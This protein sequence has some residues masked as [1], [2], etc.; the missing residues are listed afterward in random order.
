[1]T[2]YQL[3]DFLS[4]PPPHEA[5]P[6]G[7]L[8]VG[9]D[10]SSQRLILA[11]SEGIFPWFSPGDPILWWS[12]DPR[13]VL[14]PQDF[15]VSKSLART[16]RKEPF[17]I[18]WDTAFEEI[19]KNCALVP[20]EGQ[21]G[22]WIT[23]EMIDAYHQLHKIGLAHSVEAYEGDKLVGGLYGISLG[24]VFFGESMFSL[25]TDASKICF[26]HLAKQA[27]QWNFHFIDCQLPTPHL[28]SL[29]AVELNR[30]RF[31]VELEEALTL[32]TILG[33]WKQICPQ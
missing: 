24:G 10:L 17:Q 28:A 33:K 27:E 7:L 31:L 2:I 29:G 4:F 16:L 20:R 25:K 23:E 30:S 21:D 13:M 1:M 3:S 26:Y 18:K 12:P 22:T 9:G 32:R 6:E 15:K 19:V 11:Y 8:A 14:Y 5:E